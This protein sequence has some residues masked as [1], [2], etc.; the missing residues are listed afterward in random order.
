MDGP[1]REKHGLLGF[2]L[3]PG[4]SE[5]KR[6]RAASPASTAMRAE[7][8]VRTCRVWAIRQGLNPDSLPW[9]VEEA[10]DELVDGAVRQ[11]AAARTQQQQDIVA[12]YRAQLREVVRLRREEFG[13]RVSRDPH[14]RRILVN[15]GVLADFNHRPLA[16]MRRCRTQRWRSRRPRR[17]AVGRKSAARAPGE[18]EPDDDAPTRPVSAPTNRGGV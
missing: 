7:A 1:P 9:R 17:S 13:D 14:V 11:P 12:V 18:P 5:R 10:I 8:Q 15:A 16:I 2:R 6:A 4:G 3:L